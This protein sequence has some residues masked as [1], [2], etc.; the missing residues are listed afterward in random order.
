MRARSSSS[1]RTQARSPPS[2]T[3]GSRGRGQA[4]VRSAAWARAGHALAPAATGSPARRQPGSPRPAAGQR[5]RAPAATGPPPG[6]TRSSGRGSRRRCRCPRGSQRAGRRAGRAARLRRAPSGSRRTG[7]GNGREP[8]R[9]SD[10]RQ[11]RIHGHV[12]RRPARLDRHA[13]HGRQGQVPHHGRRRRG[14]RGPRPPAATIPWQSPD[15]ELRAPSESGKH[16][17]ALTR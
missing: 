7:T 8:R 14:T 10:R 5:T 2:M 12:C 16:L 3:T 6:R 9:M 13:A 11:P 17:S 15:P 1:R 4:G